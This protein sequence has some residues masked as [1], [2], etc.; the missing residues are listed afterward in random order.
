MGSRPH[1]WIIG[2]TERLVA[3]HRAL[4]DA[5]QGAGIEAVLVSPS[6]L[7]LQMDERGSRV[8]LDAASVAAPDLVV[9][10]G[11]N[12]AWPLLR[13]VLMLL[14]RAGSTV[15]PQVSA[16]DACADKVVTTMKLAAAGVPVLPSVAVA[17]GAGVALP[18]LE[19]GA[20]SA[21]MVVKPARGSKGAGVE[22]HP[23][24]RSAED[25]LCAT[26]PLVAGF[27]DHHV[28]Q[29]LATGAGIDYRVVVS[30]PA[31]GQPPQVEAITRRQARPGGIVTDGPVADVT[32][33]EVPEV[34]AVA[35]RAMQVL[36]LPFGGVDVIEHEAAMVVLEVNAWPG[37]AAE[38]RGRQ[39]ADAL[40]RVVL[41]RV[42]P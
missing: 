39:L 6:R 23:N 4:L 13:E 15:V 7:A 20:A 18:T 17:P 22:R 35:V 31:P 8:L 10:R 14:E 2:Y 42:G 38:V 34:A 37:L 11:V 29:P 26:R 3:D 41:S 19:P 36:D 28:A 33:D 12:R 25:A 24:M 5:A 27:V 9:P 21:A 1:L 16:V 30:V 40:V 32:P